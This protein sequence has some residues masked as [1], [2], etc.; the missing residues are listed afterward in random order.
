MGLEN[1]TAVTGTQ[2]ARVR[3]AYGAVVL[4]QGGEFLKV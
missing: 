1:S 4:I 2:G 3:R